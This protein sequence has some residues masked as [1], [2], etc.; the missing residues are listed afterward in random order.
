[1]RAQTGC[2]IQNGRTTWSHM[3]CNFTD[4]VLCEGKLISSSNYFTLF[5][6]ISSSFDVIVVAV[7]HFNSLWK[8]LTNV[9]QWWIQ[10]GITNETNG[11]ISTLCYSTTRNVHFTLVLLRAKSFQIGV[12]HSCYAFGSSSTLYYIIIIAFTAFLV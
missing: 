7:C 4:F 9:L 8:F 5:S 3:C 2:E 12:N 11:T 1:M 6:M 10:T